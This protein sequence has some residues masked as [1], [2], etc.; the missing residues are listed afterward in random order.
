AVLRPLA[1]AGP[2]TAAGGDRAGGLSRVQPALREGDQGHGAKAGRSVQQLEPSRRA[3]CLAA[4][5][6]VAREQGASDRTGHGFGA[7][8][9]SV[10]EGLVRGERASS[11]GGV[12]GSSVDRSICGLGE[13]GGGDIAHTLGAA[14]AGKPSPGTAEALG[15]N[16]RRVWTY[17]E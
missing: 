12:R 5:L 15:T 14:A 17:G 10:R 6:G 9:F 4:D 7:E 13:T 8:Y 16:P 3:L 11:A 2:G 1:D